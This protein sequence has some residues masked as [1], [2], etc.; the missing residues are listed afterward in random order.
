MLRCPIERK[1]T[2]QEAGRIVGK[3]GGKK[4]QKKD[5]YYVSR[6]RFPDKPNSRIPKEGLLSPSKKRGG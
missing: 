5:I 3:R 1:D 6:K 4:K 2:F